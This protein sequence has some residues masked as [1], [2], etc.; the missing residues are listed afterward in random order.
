M[1]F[2]TVMMNI[3][4]SGLDMVKHHA[5]EI[6]TLTIQKNINSPVNGPVNSPVNGPVNGPEQLLD[7]I[8]ANPGLRKAALAALL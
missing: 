8:K 3:L 2:L 6:E 4:P 5:I 7:I 1:P